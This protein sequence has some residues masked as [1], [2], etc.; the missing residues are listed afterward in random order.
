MSELASGA[1]GFGV[2]VGLRAL[3]PENGDGLA[4]SVTGTLVKMTV[5]LVLK[6]SLKMSVKHR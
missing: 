2:A 1:N 4:L 5:L 6:G 3:L